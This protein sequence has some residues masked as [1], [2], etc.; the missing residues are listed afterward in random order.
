MRFRS[1]PRQIR[2]S[3]APLVTPFTDGGEVDHEGLRTLVR[4]QLTAGTHGIS[5]GGSTGEPSA[6]SIAERAAARADRD[7]RVVVDQDVFEHHHDSVAATGARDV[8]RSGD[9]VGQ[10]RPAVEAGHLSLQSFTPSPS[11][12]LSAQLSTTGASTTGAIRSGP[13]ATVK[14]TEAKR[15]V[16]DDC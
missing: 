15:S 1:D 7:P 12:S 13:R 14:P 3:I 2:G 6:Q 5:L 16:K 9:G 11:P 10:R 8:D 4:W